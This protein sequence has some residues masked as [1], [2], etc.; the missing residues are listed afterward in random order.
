MSCARIA[1]LLE[2][3]P[4]DRAARREAERVLPPV[5]ATRLAGHLTDCAV[6][7]ELLAKLTR[8]HARLDPTQEAEMKPTAHDLR[9]GALAAMRRARA[10]AAPPA[11]AGD[12]PALPRGSG[13]R[14][15][16]APRRAAPSVLLLSIASLTALIVGGIVVT[17]AVRPSAPP[18]DDQ[19]ELLSIVAEGREGE[20]LFREWNRARHTG[21]PDEQRLH[22]EAKLRLQSAVERLAALLSRPPYSD[23]EGTPRPE[24]EGYERPLQDWATLLV[25]LEKGSTLA[26]GG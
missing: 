25:D 3:A 19:S 22:Q 12:S 26:P 5:E 4:L 1:P 9:A 24:Y 10:A 2:Q 23:A 21:S 7:R 16:S 15:T 11:P 14:R 18:R 13:Q 20:R 6:C 17:R 8:A